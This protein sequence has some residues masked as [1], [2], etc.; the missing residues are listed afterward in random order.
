MFLPIGD[1]PNSRTTPYVNYAI[2]IANVAIF[3]LISLPLTFQRV[4]ANDPTLIDYL[5][6]MVRDTGAGPRDILTRMSAYDLFVFNHGF[7]PGAP[8]VVDLFVSLFLHAGWLHLAG[9]MLFLWIFGDNVE[10]RIGRARYLLLY[11]GAG[12]VA[13]LFFSLLSLG[14]MVPLVGASGAISGVLGAYFSWFPRN[15]VRVLV[16]LF[17]FVDVI[18]LP[19]RW[20]LGFYLL[21]DNLLPF[22][23]GQGAGG[24]AYGA[25]IGGFFAGLGGSW[26]MDRWGSREATLHAWVRPADAAPTHVP[27]DPL[28]ENTRF[29][30]A[31]RAGQWDQAVRVYAGMALHERQ[32]LL[33]DD[34][35]HMTDWLTEVGRGDTA[36]AVLQ[37]YIATHPLGAALPAAHLRAGLLQ[38]RERGQP[39]AAYQH[40]LTVLDLAPHGAQADAARAA[41]SEIESHRQRLH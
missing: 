18:R 1:E 12:V 20:V 23:F 25:H 5:Q 38:L 3:V 40:L 37:R 35:L 16:W 29:D 41:L 22:V 27:P 33:D 15:R 24:V 30:A 4:D 6:V 2:L 36:L 26:L 10:H 7:R 13:T 31:A 9:N 32:R 11:L 28:A 14:S 8:A 17:I 39:T 34:V 19:A 21:V